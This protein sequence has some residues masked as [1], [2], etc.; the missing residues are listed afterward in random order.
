MR[1]YYATPNGD[2]KPYYYVMVNGRILKRSI[3]RDKV[4]EWLKSN[5]AL[6]ASACKTI[7][8][9]QVAKQLMVACNRLIV[10]AYG[11]CLDL[12]SWE[13][14]DYLT[15]LDL[16]QGWP[17]WKLSKGDKNEPKE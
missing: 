2:K 14:P 16:T 5:K 17:G 1:I 11:R 4:V 9:K 8:K 13:C 3:T 7:K 10:P 15:C 12:K 6:V